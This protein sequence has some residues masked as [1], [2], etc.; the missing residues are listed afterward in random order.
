MSAKTICKSSLGQLLATEFYFILNML[1]T[2]K[3]SAWANKR[4][5]LGIPNPM[6]PGH[7]DDLCVRT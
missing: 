5:A 3:R 6:T 4:H 1:Q 2:T 7:I